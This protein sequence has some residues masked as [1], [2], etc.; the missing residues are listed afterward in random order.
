MEQGKSQIIAQ[1]IKRFVCLIDMLLNGRY[2]RA[3]YD[4]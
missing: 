2:D 1:K 3:E 4:K